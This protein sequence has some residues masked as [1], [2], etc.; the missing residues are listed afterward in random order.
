LKVRVAEISY[1]LSLPASLGEE[2]AEAALRQLLPDPDAD[3][4]NNW[5]IL[6]QRIQALASATPADGSSAS[7]ASGF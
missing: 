5:R 4:V 2:L 1:S 3:G 7:A 6:T